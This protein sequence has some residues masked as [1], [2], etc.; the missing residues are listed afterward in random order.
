MVLCGGVLAGQQSLTDAY[1][2]VRTSDNAWHWGQAGELPSARHRH[3]ATTIA[4]QL[5]VVGWRQGVGAVD[6]PEGQEVFM[7]DSATAAW[8]LAAVSADHL[9]SRNWCGWPLFAYMMPWCLAT[10]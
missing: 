7:M 3:T 2:L 1:H 4:D 6:L 10:R 5:Y 8:Q 9:G